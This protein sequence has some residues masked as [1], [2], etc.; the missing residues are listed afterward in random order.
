[1]VFVGASPFAETDRQTQRQTHTT[2][3][4]KNIIFASLLRSFGGYVIMPTIIRF[5]VF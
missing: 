1:M 5:F 3:T 2:H 4:N